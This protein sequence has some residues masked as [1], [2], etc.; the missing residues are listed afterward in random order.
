MNEVVIVSAARTPIGS[1]NGALSSL[2]AAQ[3]GSKAIKGALDKIDLDP[4]IVE[5]V[6]MGCVLQANLGMNPAR[7]SALEA[8]L[9]NKVPCTTVN[10][11]CASGMKSISLAA[12]SI[13]LGKVDIAIAGGMENMSQVPHYIPG[14][15]AGFKFGDTKL[16][17]GIIKDGLMNV[18]DQNVM[19]VLA[20]KCAS[21][22][23]FSRE[24][25]DKFALESYQRSSKAWDNGKFDDEV[26]P[27]EIKDRRGNITVVDEDEE[28]KNINPEKISKLRPAF[29]KDGTVTAAN[30][31][32]LNDGAAALVL[33]SAEKAKELGI[34]PLAKLLSHSDYS[35]EPEWFTTA[36]AKAVPKA[37]KS[38]GL[39]IEEIDFFELNEAFSVVGLVNMKL[40]EIDP[41]KTNVNGGAVSLGHPLGCSGARIV[42]TLLNVLGQNKGRYGAAGVCNGG[43]GASALVIEKL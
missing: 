36:P 16:I 5:E 23:D 8:G 22:Y 30:A 20:D 15:R 41:N 13:Q 35:H 42:V 17:D 43:G 26:V 24:A 9:S 38:A 39:N 14:T 28:F 7:Q 11:V 12:Q 6:Y 37:I 1:F 2:S 10:K 21:T 33:M 32:T 29:T 27:I 3:L 31:S 18:Y 40:L 4:S 34:T 25:Q 19:G